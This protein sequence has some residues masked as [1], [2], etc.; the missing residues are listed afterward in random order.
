MRLFGRSKESDQ[1]TD[2]ALERTRRSFFGRMSEIFRG[3]D[4]TEELWESLEEVLIGADTGVTTTMELLDR[5]RA[6]NPSQAED[7]RRL[8]REE[9]LAILRAPS[10]ATQ[11]RLWG[12]PDDAP[13][14]DRPWVVLI[15]GVNGSGKTTAVGRLAFA[16][17]EQGRKV[18]AAAGDTFRA[19]AIEQLQNW[20]RRLNFE[21]I[22]HQQGADPAAIAYDTI[23]AARARG[24]DVVLIDTAGRLQSKKNLMDELSKVRRVIERHVDR[25]PDE[26]LLVLDAT[27][28]QN[29]LSQARAFAEAVDVTSVMLTKLDSSAKG[30]IVFAI[31]QE[32]GLPVRFVGVGQEP[33]DLAP[34]DPE[35]FV[36]AL[37]GHADEHERVTAGASGD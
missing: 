22:A 35:A 21:V 14:P 3:S 5:V 10:E 7:V 26:V 29:G 18:I 2:Q 20:G 17:Q 24:H 6:K 12:L 37:L 25:G 23:E 1:A 8:L 11:G 31:A 36:D 4:V 32:F 28:G 15:V 27:T 13:E 33:G 9:L 19:A 34:F 30:G 16:Y